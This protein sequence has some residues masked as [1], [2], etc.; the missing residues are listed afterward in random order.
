[1]LD[2]MSAGEFDD[3]CEF[4]CREPW[5]EHRADRRMQRLVWAILQPYTKRRLRESDFALRF[6]IKTA[7]DEGQYK[8]RS[9]QR[10]GMMAAHFDRKA[11]KP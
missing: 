7:T 3:W 1:M 4:Y 10:Y 5:G 6:D 8:A 2:E 11:G 9:M